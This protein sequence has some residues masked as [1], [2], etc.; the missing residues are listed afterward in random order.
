M[1]HMDDSQSSDSFNI[2]SDINENRMID[3]IRVVKKKESLQKVRSC[4]STLLTERQELI[5]SLEA[6]YNLI[7]ALFTD[8]DDL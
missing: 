8:V 7:T 4:I 1:R 2:A 3:D 5:K 6:S